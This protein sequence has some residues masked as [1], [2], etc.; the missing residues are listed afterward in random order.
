VPIYLPFYLPLPPPVS[1]PTRKSTFPPFKSGRSHPS[2]PFPPFGFKETYFLPSPKRLPLSH[3]PQFTPPKT[4][5]SWGD[6]PNQ[7]L[8]SSMVCSTLP[9]P[10]DSPVH[11][12]FQFPGIAGVFFRTALTRV[13]FSPTP[14]VHRCTIAARSRLPGPLTC[15]VSGRSWTTRA[16]FPP[17]LIRQV[18]FRME[19]K[20]FRCSPTRKT[21][22]LLQDVFP[23]FNTLP[24]CPVLPPRMSFS[25][26]VE[27]ARLSLFFIVR[28]L[29][30]K[31]IFKPIDRSQLHW[32]G[33]ITYF[34][35]GPQM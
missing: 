33:A 3:F 14:S 11:S 8:P 17:A 28:F 19:R 35:F 29:L 10:N 32:H 24:Q 9:F 1:P 2:T 15:E 26:Q 22:L 21:S 20:S 5:K 25:P 13:S 27:F 12:R 16:T 30:L 4:I 31:E 18:S 34:A 7:C 23:V 6:P